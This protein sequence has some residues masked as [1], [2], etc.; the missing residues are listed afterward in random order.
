MNYT[1]LVVGAGL[2]GG[3]YYILEMGQQNPVNKSISYKTPK[4]KSQP[5]N[6]RDLAPRNQE[7]NNSAIGRSRTYSKY[8]QKGLQNKND[9]FSKPT[10]K[11]V[12]DK[13]VYEAKQQQ[14]EQTQK[15][16]AKINDGQEKKNKIKKV[17]GNL[18]MAEQR[19]RLAKSTSDRIYEQQQIAQFRQQIKKL[20][21]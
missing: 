12:T 18:M 9:P 3:G 6:L 20:S 19:L 2:I 16:L 13:Q 21:K 10:T 7:K 11:I 1:I 8:N 15:V 14:L 4:P 17:V 5:D